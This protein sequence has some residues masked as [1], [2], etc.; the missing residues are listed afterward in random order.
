MR[1]LAAAV[2]ATA[3]A[4]LVVPLAASA[5]PEGWQSEWT[6]TAD[7]AFREDPVLAFTFTHTPSPAT[8]PG[9]E[10]VRFSYARADGQPEPIAGCALPTPPEVVA[11]PTRDNPHTLSSAIQVVLPCNGRYTVTAVATT[12]TNPLHAADSSPPI[13]L[14]FATAVPSAAPTELSVEATE[15]DGD[16]AAALRWLAPD[17]SPPDLVGYVIERSRAADDGF[18]VVGESVQPSFVDAEAAEG[19]VFHY[20]VRAM[21]LGPGEE[22]V[23]SPTSTTAAVDVPAPVVSTTS[24]TTARGDSG[25][26]A[27]DLSGFGSLQQQAGRLRPDA[28]A[29]SPS[30]TLTTVDTGFQETLPFDPNNPGAVTTA[31]AP[32]DGGLAGASLQTFDDGDGSDRKAVLAPIAGAL[33]L[34]VAFLQLRWLLRQAS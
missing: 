6:V 3:A 7:E 18:E 20:R 25:R 19:G 1:R 21:R 26:P 15:V 5:H 2:T 17:P 23:P 22:L 27:G 14:T 4:L 10:R 32:P 16:A 34:L 29:V 13:S 28:P 30:G 33:A 8:Q 9:I 11:S 12:A 24:T 31:S